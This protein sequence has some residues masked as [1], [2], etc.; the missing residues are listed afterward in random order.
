MAILEKIRRRFIFLVLVIGLA[1]F[2]FVI[3][4]VFNVD[5]AGGSND[6]VGIINDEK[7]NNETF[8]FQVEQITRNYDVSNLRAVNIAWKQILRDY[9]FEKEFEI[10]GIDA[11]E[12]QIEQ[13]IY[14][15]ENLIQQPRFQNQAGFF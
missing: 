12:E 4:G 13:S 7:I 3:S 15:D 9:I 6:P 8:S 10:L 14:A 1:L 5:N 11:G 2:S